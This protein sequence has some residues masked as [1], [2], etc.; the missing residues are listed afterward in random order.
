MAREGK[1]MTQRELADKAGISE[2]TVATIEAGVHRPRFNTMKRLAG[3][4]DLDPMTI[5]WPTPVGADNT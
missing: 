3:A 4:L 5:D 1:L 2:S